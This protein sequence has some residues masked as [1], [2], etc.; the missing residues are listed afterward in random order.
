MAAESWQKEAKR[1]KAKLDEFQH[2]RSS[3]TIFRHFARQAA[4]RGYNAT[5]ILR[6]FPGLLKSLENTSNLGYSFTEA[7]ADSFLELFRESSGDSVDLEGDFRKRCGLEKMIFMPERLTA[8]NGA[9]AALMGEFHLNRNV[10]CPECHGE[11]CEDC[12][13]VGGWSEKIPVDWTTIKEIYAK[14][15]EH[16]REEG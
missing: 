9:K 5:S 3:L 8:E 2:D 11:G 4:G 10:T 12:K 1:L 15:V 16:F 7:D 13:G 6:S 14:A